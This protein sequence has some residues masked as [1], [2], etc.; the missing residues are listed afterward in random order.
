EPEDRNEDDHTSIKDKCARENHSEIEKRRRNKMNAY[1]AELSNMLPNCGSLPRRPDKLTILKMAV[2]HMKSLRKEEM[3]SRA[4]CRS[5]FL[6]DQEIK[7][8][9]LEAA[10]GFLFVVSCDNGSLLYV[11]D[12][13]SNVLKLSQDDWTG[14]SLYELAHP[15]DTSKIRE[16]LS[17][18]EVSQLTNGIFYLIILNRSDS[19]ARKSFICRMR[20][21]SDN[22]DVEYE[23]DQFSSTNPNGVTTR[24][25]VVHCAGYIRSWPPTGITDD[26]S[27]ESSFSSF[28]SENGIGTCLVAIGKLLLATAPTVADEEGTT[29]VSRHDINGTFTF[30]D[31]RITSVT[32]FLPKDL[33][34]KNIVNYCHPSDRELLE[35]SFKQVL[36]MK[37]QKLRINYRFRTVNNNWIWLHNTCYSFLNP[38]SGQVEYIV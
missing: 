17:D 26:D 34:G 18:N 27:S 1:V 32:G 35:E 21:G 24:Y 6:S 20:Y 30:I 9:I 14:R 7:Q 28:G 37:N 22:Y 12:A 15:E 25:K 5:S 4:V 31:Q 36:T 8:L 11:S 10:D 13:I 3:E 16:Q 2:S 29:F 33:L 38:C 23:E 19:G